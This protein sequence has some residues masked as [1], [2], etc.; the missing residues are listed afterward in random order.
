MIYDLYIHQLSHTHTHTV[1]YISTLK[2]VFTML[3]GLYSLS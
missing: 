1:G 2:F 3:F